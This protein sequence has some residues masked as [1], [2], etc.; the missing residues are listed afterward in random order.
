MWGVAGCTLTH[1]PFEPSVVDGIRTESVS[2]LPGPPELTVEAASEQGGPAA[3]SPEV[4]GELQPGLGSLPELVPGEAS[5]EEVGGSSPA[6]VLDAPRLDAGAELGDAAAPAPCLGQ[7]LSSS[8]Y[9]LFPEPLAWEAAEQ[10]CVEWGGHLASVGSAEEDDFL[11]GWLA[12]LGEGGPLVLGTWLGGT[13]AEDDGEFIWS[14]GAPLS[15]D[16]WGPDQPNNGAGVD[17]IE[18]RSD[19]AARWHDQRCDDERQYVCERSR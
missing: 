7:T 3:V 15:Y 19:E 13:D 9:E 1:D 11:A 6:G 10:R 2:G 8:C 12:A 4:S 17:C 18:K 16:A 14:D 5:G